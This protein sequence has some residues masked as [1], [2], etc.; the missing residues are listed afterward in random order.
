MQLLQLKFQYKR[1]L[2]ASGS[3]GNGPFWQ[4][5]IRQDSKKTIHNSV[6]TYI[7]IK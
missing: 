2:Y 4:Q 5:C 6:K 1:Q 3:A 7:L